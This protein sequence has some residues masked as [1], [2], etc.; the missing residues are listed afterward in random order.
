MISDVQVFFLYYKFINIVQQH[1]PVKP[2][3]NNSICGS[4][5]CILTV[6]FILRLNKYLKNKP[7]TI[8]LVS[9]SVD[10]YDDGCMTSWYS[11][12]LSLPIS[13]K[14]FVIQLQP[15]ILA[16]RV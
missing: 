7:H 15:W 16:E 13:V 5:Q 8:V 3:K 9:C 6:I 12:N 2:K 14:S 1:Y 4:I 11:P 10:I